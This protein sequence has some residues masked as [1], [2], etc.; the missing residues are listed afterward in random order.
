MTRTRLPGPRSPIA[1]ADIGLRLLRDPYETP[2]R[3]YRD[4]GPVSSVG[5][6]PFRY[7]YLLG[8][9]ANEFILSSHHHLF[10]WREAFKALIPV[11]GDTAL[12][13]SDGED[14]ARR[15]RL[16]QPAF[17]RRRIDSYVP[18][19]VDEAQRTVGA[20]AGRSVVDLHVEFKR[21]IRRIA[22]RT[23]FGDTLGDRAEVIGDA[24]DTAIAYANLP[25]FLVWNH[26]LPFTPYRRA[27][28]AR[29]VVDRIVL[30]EIARRRAGPADEHDLLSSLI[31]A[32][33]DADQ[34]SEEE[35]TDQVVSLIA[36][37][38]ETTAALVAWTAYA[39]LSDAAVERTLREELAGLGDDRSGGA[40]GDCAYLDAVVNET[41]RLHGP[42][43]FSARFAPEAFEFAGHTVPARST[44][45][46]SSYVSHRLAE[47]WDDPLNFDPRRWI[48]GPPPEPYVFVP[49]GGG[50]RRCIGFALATIETKVLIAELFRTTRLTLRSTDV[51]PT[52]YVTMWPKGGIEVE[53]HR[54]STAAS[55]GGR[56][57]SP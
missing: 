37:G 6:G 17:G 34:L 57:L 38:Y 33:E 50:Y 13:V 1:Q 47:H 23:L 25:P 26:D 3:L 7:V 39:I 29:R 10:E 30:D 55:T 45:A 35:V 28:R 24:L 51:R 52:G 20:I 42:A 41:L 12:V 15:R 19:I 36:A 31:A 18:V 5:H 46:Y 48:D 14:H 9:E 21:A 56:A 44:I 8:R 53:V 32:S 49:F 16:V 40:V 22:I 54:S 11:D 27:M 4:H 43:P 2:L